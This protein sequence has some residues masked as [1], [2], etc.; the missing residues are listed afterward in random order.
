MSEIVLR[1]RNLTKRYGKE[2]AVKDVG[3]TVKKGEIY[4][5]IGKNGAGKTTLI[6]LVTGLIHKTRG[7]I[8]LMGACSEKDLH[9]ARTMIGSIVGFPY[10]Y[11]NMTARENLEVSRLVRNIAGEKCLYEALALVGLETTGKKKVKSF[12]MGMKQRLGIANA[13]LGDPRFLILDEPV[14]GLDPI[15]IVEMRELFKKVNREKEVTIL[16]SSHILEELSAIAT[17]YGIIDNGR[18]VEEISAG[19]LR[20]KC[21]RYIEIDVIKL[22]NAVVILEEK[23]NIRDYEVLPNHIIRVFSHLDAV[24]EIN[25][26]LLKEGVTVN[27]IG[28]KGQNLEDYFIHA[29]GGNADA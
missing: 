20:E 25:A 12:S 8:E 9:S 7:D 14:N 26:S 24:G 3:M 21:Q 28:L 15:S 11:G 22:Q 5:F 18:L 13:L 27:Q 4:G 17:A 6:R 10:F 1:T 16:I 23:F 2:F 19:E 29:I